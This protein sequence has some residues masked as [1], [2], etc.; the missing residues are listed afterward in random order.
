MYTINGN[1][2]TPHKPTGTTLSPA[3]WVPALTQ[4]CDQLKTTYYQ[5][6]RNGDN[7]GAMAAYTHLH[8]IEDGY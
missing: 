7:A 5:C 3:T 2:V 4:L 8:E 6:K 1:T